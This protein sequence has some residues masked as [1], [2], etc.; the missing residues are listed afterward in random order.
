MTTIAPE[1]NLP[2]DHPLRQILD[3]IAAHPEVREP[4]LRVL[5]TE[6][7]LTL[8]EQVRELRAGFTEFKEE[9]REQFRAVNERIDETNRSLGER[10]DETNR[11]LGER[12]D[13]TNRSLG[14]RI[15]ETNR[16]LG[17]RIDE[18]NRRIDETNRSLGERIDETN[19]TLG[20][21]I[22][23]TNRRIDENIRLTRSIQGAVGALRGDSYEDLCRKEIEVILDGW[24][25]RA[26]L[27]DRS[28][29][30]NR[31]GALR[32][33]NLISRQDFLD[34]LRPDIIA[35]AKNDTEQSRLFAVVEVSITFNRSDLETAARRA[36]IVSEA[37]GVP[38]NAYVVTNHPWPDDMSQLSRQLGVTIIRHEAPQYADL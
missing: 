13:E 26:V 37:T 5:L 33:D 1:L 32:H 25:E 17:E 6:D 22:D 4:I 27:A 15:D 38:A 3:T 16:T 24:L 11:S 19:R 12:I 30:N 36:R 9:T 8:P 34:G 23:E 7:F 18:T 10:I 29:V 21:R 28:R 35:R 2:P 14:E 20:E 31:L